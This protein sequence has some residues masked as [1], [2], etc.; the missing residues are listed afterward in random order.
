[1]ATV[2]I[3]PPDRA[4]CQDPIWIQ[5]ETNKIVPDYAY[6]NVYV[7]DSDGLGAHV[8]ITWPGGTLLFTVS[9]PTEN[10][11]DWP[12][13]AGLPIINY[14]DN[15]EE[16]FR[17]NEIIT[18]NFK[19]IR[20]SDQVI[21]L[22]SRLA[23]P[24]TFTVSENT[25]DA[26]VI[27]AVSTSALSQPD[28]LRALVEVYGDTGD[29]ETDPLLVKLHAPYDFNTYL[30]DIDLSAAFNL[31]PHLPDAAQ[32]NPDPAMS[33]LTVTECETVLKRY[34]FRY[35][36]KYGTPAISEKLRK[37]T[38]RYTAVWG[39]LTGDT[40]RTGPEFLCH[41]YRRADGGTFVKPV[42]D[43]QPDWLYF[44]NFD[45]VITTV[46]V[47]VLIY[48]SDMTT[49]SYNPFGTTPIGIG[50]EKIY[51]IPVGYNQ[52]KLNTKTPGAGTATNATIVS[53]DVRLGPLDDSLNYRT[54]IKYQLYPAAYYGHYLLFSNGLGGCETVALRGKGFQGIEPTA[55]LYQRPRTAS[56]GRVVNLEQGDFSAYN[57]K[58]RRTWE[59]S[60]GLYSDPFYIRHLQQLPMGDAWLVDIENRR[61]LKVIVDAKGF[62]VSEDDANLFSATFTLRAGWQDQSFNI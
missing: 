41:N 45:T 55:E 33:A 56:E 49:Q 13:A 20:V 12:Y 46:F 4:F 18:D 51:N 15:I 10:A 23:I 52:L 1:M 19:I 48:W 44:F 5:I 43:E 11:T 27:T 21:R 3:Y 2:N 59:F 60:T 62:Q 14:T 61:F 25:M 38:D 57:Q 24:Q 29:T 54:V 40:L 37:T 7:P 28:N 9:D 36:D 17:Q 35:A 6:F 31:K 47:N 58:A 50:T 42:T 39:S 32:I 30:A 26:T 22:Y 8:R 53:Y 34:Y 16:F